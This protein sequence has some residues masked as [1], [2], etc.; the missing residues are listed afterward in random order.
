[1]R[2]FLPLA[3]ALAG[4]SLFLTGCVEETDVVY[5]ERPALYGAAADVDFYY[6]GEVPYSRQYGMLY[7]RDNRYYYRQNNNFVF[8]SRP[9]LDR[10][11]YY[12][13]YR[14][15]NDRESRGL[16]DE[17]Y[18]RWDRQRERMNAARRSQRTDWQPVADERRNEQKSRA[19]GTNQ[20][21][22]DE[23]QRTIER[24]KTAAN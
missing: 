7:Y 23:V 12:A 21:S 1:M 18:I 20:Q 24:R 11:D 6:V 9:V 8:Y 16:W 2:T 3:I 4:C 22:D 14:V 10:T 5:T 15:D 13:R 17:R 19:R